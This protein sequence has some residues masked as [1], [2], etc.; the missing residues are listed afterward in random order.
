M[1]ESEINFL[2]P[3]ICEVAYS[4]QFEPLDTLH[5][6]L[7]GLLW[8]EKL[9]E[10]YP[11]VEQDDPLPHEIERFGARDT[12]LAVNKLR[13]VE[14]LPLP[15][16]RIVSSDSCSLL[17]I[18]ND[19]F[20]FNWRNHFSKES[21][22]YPRFT[23]LRDRFAK[24]FEKFREFVSENSLGELR[25]NQVEIT[26]VNHILCNGMSFSD[27]FAGLQCGVDISEDLDLQAISF[28][29]THVIKSKDKPVGR[30]YSVIEKAY[31][32]SDNAEVFKLTFTARSNIDDTSLDGA[33]S[34]LANLRDKI[35]Q[36]FVCLTKEEMHKAWGREEK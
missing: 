25:L 17:Q 24:D 34:V 7:L 10:R 15:R 27:V 31:R 22:E 9:R 6:G 29:T 14:K 33:F 35:N 16:M 23:A 18:Q 12:L 1:P 3:P 20:V 4:F 32:K 8:G 28:R 36:S 21:V 2:R 30:L 26:N 11:L 5:M 13:F 19:R